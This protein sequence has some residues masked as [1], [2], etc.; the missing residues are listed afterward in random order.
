[1]Q[2]KHRLCL[3]QGS[4][5]FT[6]M[7]PSTTMKIVVLNMLFIVS[8]SVQF[9]KH[10][11]VNHPSKYSEAKKYCNEKFTDLSPITSKRDERRLRN[12]TFGKVDKRFWIGLYRDGKQWKWSGGVNATNIPWGPQQPD[13]FKE[14]N[15]TSICWNKCK[16]K[17][18]H[19]TNFN[20][21]LPFFCL[22]LI[23]MKHKATWEQALHSC[24]KNHATLTSLVSEAEHL[25]ALRNIQKQ[26]HVTE[27]VWIG[28]RYLGDDWLWMD[29]SPLKYQAWSQGDENQ[30]PIWKRCG[31]LTKEGLWEGW[32]CGDKLNFICY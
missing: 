16:W 23:V 17:G 6:T 20:E 5:F 30:C 12:A 29:R 7:I 10:V 18:W 32:D 25:L 15:C 21:K 27:R 22:N 26:Q 11:Y 2:L 13:D 3:E 19:N 31:T 28:L 8:V 24:E 4:I 9:G 14:E 1:M